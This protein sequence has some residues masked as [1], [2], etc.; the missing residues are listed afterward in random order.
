MR[1]GLAALLGTLWLPACAQSPPLLVPNPGFEEVD[2][3][4]GFARGW[5]RGVS[6]GTAGSAELDS[7]VARS[8]ERSLRITDATPQQ[9]YRYVLVNTGWL[10]ARPETTYLLRFHARGKGV[11]RCFAGVALEGAG[12]SRQ[13]LPAGDYDWR[14]LTFR[15][16]TPAGS[17]RIQV[18]FLADGVTEGLWIDDVSIERSPVQLANIAERRAPA[19]WTHWY[20]RTPGPMPRRLA[21]L[22]VSGEGPD[23]T[24]LMTALQGIVNRRAPRLYLIQPTNPPRYDEM[25]LATLRE[26]GYTGPEERLASPSEALRRFRHAYRG[27]VVWDPDLPGSRHA[28]W[29]LAGIEDLLPASPETAARFRLPIVE[30]L[31]GRWTRN[32]DAYRWVYERHW[33]RMSHTLLAWE[34]PESSALS[35]RDVMVQ[36]RV[37]LFWVSSPLDNER[38]ADP[39]AE[40][41]FLEELLAA[42][43]GN[44]P[45]MGWPMYG[46]RG[47]DEY[48]GVR[49]LSEYAKWVPGTGFNSNGTVH[50]AVRPPRSAFR[51]HDPPGVAPPRLDRDKVFLSIS[52]MD[53]GDAHWYWQLYQR[54]IWADPARGRVPTGYGMNMTLVDALPAVAEWYY[55]NRKQRDTFFGLLYM[56]A[57]VYAA[58][59]RRADRERIWAEFVG[60]TARYLER[61]DMEGLEIYTGG[62][63][64]PPAPRELLRRFT[65]GIPGLRYLLAGLGRHAG[66][67]PEAAA[68]MLDGVAVFHTLTNFRV[69]TSGADL[70]ARTMES[71][72]AWLM[73]EIEANTPAQRPAFMS[74]MAISWSYYPAWLVDLWARLPARYAA[75][76]PAELARLYRQWGSGQAARARARTPAPGA[77]SSPRRRARP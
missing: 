27:A 63:S 69:W 8:G 61:L 13:G 45:V 64:G 33:P 36:Q 70:A 25:W 5:T 43:P 60:R 58:R 59:F 20:P 53:S 37:F 42:T 9:A 29:M 15:F 12:E 72:N 57:P 17:G 24:G 22:D 28:A 11:G 39:Q 62:T 19:G 55:R 7:T 44:V 32:V 49:L 71:E 31:R 76:N 47:L 40:Q 26:R 54:G 30:D 18:Q 34:H 3:S 48:A 50:S 65:R 6:E 41:E 73:A 14:V 77:P 56:N 16:T 74:A 2:P 1:L 75:V 51:Q 10:Q 68:Q 46:T 67:R 21:V 35:S 38:G 23:V 66:L 52:I 4:T